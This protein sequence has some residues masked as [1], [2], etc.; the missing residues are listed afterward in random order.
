MLGRLLARAL[1][2]RTPADLADEVRAAEQYL[3]LLPPT[4]RGLGLLALASLERELERRLEG[5]RHPS[6]APSGAA[7]LVQPPSA[8][9]WAPSA[10]MTAPETNDAAS[11]A[12]NATTRPISAG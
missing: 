5:A 1:G 2:C 4:R 11:E 7:A 12:R 3:A 9:I 8:A 6:S 10:R